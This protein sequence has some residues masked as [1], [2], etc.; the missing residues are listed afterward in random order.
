MYKTMMNPSSVQWS[1]SDQSHHVS[2]I[3]ASISYS[4]VTNMQINLGDKLIIV[5]SVQCSVV[6]KVIVFHQ[7]LKHNLPPL[8]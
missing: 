2:R 5:N 1:S 7:K 3:I 8:L 4:S 6:H